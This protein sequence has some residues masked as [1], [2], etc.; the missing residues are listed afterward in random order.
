MAW[1][2]GEHVTCVGSTGC[3][4]TDLIIELGSTR[5]WCIFLN[6]KRID[7]TQDSLR[8]MGFRTVHSGDDINPDV[9]SRYIVA[10]KWPKQMSPKTMDAYH[11]DVF[12]HA[13]TRAF[14]QT[15]W[16]VLVDELE[17]INRDLQ[18]VAPTDR[19]HRQ[20]RS[21]KNTL[22]VGTQ[23]PRHVSLHAYEQA[24]HMFLWRQSDMGNVERAAQLA[25]A[26]RAAVLDAMGTLGKHDTLYTNTDSGEM[27]VTNTRW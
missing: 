1:R 12:T 14:W 16:T 23:R 3:G 27:F 6:T 18:V 8:G 26:N 15:G 17:Y 21:Q 7:S 24:T 10:P 13:L 19:L 4:K 25:G 11:A 22:V 20:G 9:A 5:R 2:Q